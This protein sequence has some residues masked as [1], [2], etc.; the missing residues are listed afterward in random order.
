MT[1]HERLM[2]LCKKIKKGEIPYL[3]FDLTYNNTDFNKVLPL[4]FLPL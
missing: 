1:D 4:F 3:S 2:D